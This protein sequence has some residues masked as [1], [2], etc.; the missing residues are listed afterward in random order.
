MTYTPARHMTQVADRIDKLVDRLQTLANA[1]F[2]QVVEQLEQENPV[3]PRY[4]QHVH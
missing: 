4:V 3:P 1:E 2:V